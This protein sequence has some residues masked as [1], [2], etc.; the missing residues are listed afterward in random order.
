MPSI[1]EALGIALDPQVKIQGRSLLPLIRDEQAEELPA[2]MEATGG[3]LIPDQRDRLMGI[4]V[5]PWKYVFAPDNPG[6]YPELYHLGEDPRESKNLVDQHPDIAEE[7]RT[8]I[9]ATQY[10]LEQGQTDAPMT[11]EEQVKVEDRA[12]T[13]VYRLRPAA[14]S[15][16]LWAAFPP[17]PVSDGT[18]VRGSSRPFP[19]VCDP[20]RREQE[21]C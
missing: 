17:L 18:P 16:S 9:N 5:P 3:S 1:L 14:A 20:L 4:R 11:K 12:G 7:L 21:T 10:R 6:I 15:N 2:L 8:T 13:P 19:S